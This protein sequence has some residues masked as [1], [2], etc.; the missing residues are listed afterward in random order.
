MVPRTGNEPNTMPDIKIARYE[1]SLAGYWNRA[2]AE[3]RNGHFLFDRGF[4]DYHADRFSDCSLLFFKGDHLL[5]V[6]PA[7]RRG[8]TIYSHQGLTFGGIVAGD[9]LDASLTLR[10]FDALRFDLAKQG[11]RSLVYKAIPHIYHRR[12]AQDDLYALFRHRAELVRRDISS[13]IDCAFPGTSSPARRTSIR[14]AANAGL[15]FGESNHWDEYWAL[16]TACLEAHHGVRPV[17]TLTEI[18]LLHDRFPDAIRLFTS[19]SPAGV[20]VAGVVMF[21]STTVAHAQYAAVSQEG[22]SMYA[23]DGLYMFLI[24]HYRESKR[25]FDFGI[26]TEDDGRVLNAG[27]ATYKV[28][29]GAGGIAY[30]TYRLPIG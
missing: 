11:T 16:L 28:R 5:G 13:T 29:F 9:R 18:R 21:V 25:W 12:P 8:D 26:S 23:L 1:P 19:L 27:L 4:M 14:K 20:I 30:D 22:R 3:A 2:V 10:V 17:H 24:E 7:N 6:L 15:F